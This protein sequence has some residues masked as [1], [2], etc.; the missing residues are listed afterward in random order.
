MDGDPVCRCGHVREVHDHPRGGCTCCGLCGRDSCP[1][2]RRL[3]S[4]LSLAAAQ[5]INRLLAIIRRRT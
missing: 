2:Y 1:S 4:H 3:P 5:R